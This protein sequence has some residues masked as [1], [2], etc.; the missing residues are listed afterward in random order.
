MTWLS[1]AATSAGMCSLA[2]DGIALASKGL[3]TLSGFFQSTTTNWRVHGPLERT[4]QYHRLY[5]QWFLSHTDSM[6]FG[7]SE[8]RV[9]ELYVSSY[10]WRKSLRILRSP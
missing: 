6:H 2:A 3:A 7:M 4:Q 9:I 5:A 10:A 1:T 8:G